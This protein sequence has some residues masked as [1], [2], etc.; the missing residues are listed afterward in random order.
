MSANAN[1]SRA[2]QVKLLSELQGFWAGDLW[3]M[4][5]SPV[6]D[7]SPCARQRHL[8][9]RC[10]STALNGEL[11]YLCWKKFTSGEWR[12]TQEIS[13]IH[14][15]IHWLNNMP[16]PPLS[17]L[18]KDFSIWRALYRTYLPSSGRTS[19]RPNPP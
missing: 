3:D 17:L 6:K 10:K 19:T 8:R 2:T 13:R 15:M 9:F 4:H 11:K 5:H 18:E 7:L 14:R 12:S 1:W 16:T